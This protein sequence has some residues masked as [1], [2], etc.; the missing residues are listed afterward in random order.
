VTHRSAVRTLTD[1]QLHEVHTVAQA[2]VA[3]YIGNYDSLVGKQRRIAN[4]AEREILARAKH[5]ERG[6]PK[7]RLALFR[8]N[9]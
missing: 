7:F 2:K 4:A 8:S 1:E 6:R 3:S 5:A 9:V